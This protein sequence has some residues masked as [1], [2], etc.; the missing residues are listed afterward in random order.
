MESF[1]R[2]FFP[3]NKASRK[4]KVCV[5]IIGIKSDTSVLFL[6]KS[7][8]PLLYH[9][10]HIISGSYRSFHRQKMN[11]RATHAHSEMYKLA[12]C[13]PLSK[14]KLIL[15]YRQSVISF[16]CW[17]KYDG[18]CLDNIKRRP[19]PKPEILH[20]Q[21]QRVWCSRQQTAAALLLDAYQAAGCGCFLAD[22][23]FFPW[24]ETHLA[25]DNLSLVFYCVIHAK[26]CSM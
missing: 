5:M 10:Q 6:A 24:R 15:H 18:W 23:V 8:H 1:T 13:L 19:L 3:Y 20:I 22:S 14:H 2:P 4:K 16:K 25:L 21:R 12:W 17:F 11:S 7:S 26:L 9:V